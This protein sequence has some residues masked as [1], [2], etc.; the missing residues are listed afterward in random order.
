MLYWFSKE[1]PR[2]IIR[3]RHNIDSYSTRVQKY[4][5][6]FP[7][8]LHILT[9]ESGTVAINLTILGKCKNKEKHNTM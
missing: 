6:F 1:A 4:L 9:L 8:N 5:F 3:F 2:L 7:H